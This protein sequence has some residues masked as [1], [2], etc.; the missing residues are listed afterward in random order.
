MSA[1]PRT[2]VLRP[3]PGVTPEEG[4]A[5]RARA[6]RFILDAY[7]RKIPTADQ[8]GWGDHDGKTKEASADERIILPEA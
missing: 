4:R 3:L 7:R 6:W 1:E 2:V 5:S 8:G